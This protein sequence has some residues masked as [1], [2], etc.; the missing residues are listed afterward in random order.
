MEPLFIPI[1]HM[2]FSLQDGKLTSGLLVT[3]LF[4]YCH[5]FMSPECAFEMFNIR[6]QNM[7]TR[8]VPGPSQKQ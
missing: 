7:S 3:S 4:I 8:I 2:L 5:L 1:S 6:R